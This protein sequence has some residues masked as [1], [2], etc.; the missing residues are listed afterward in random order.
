[1][2]DNK[3][4]LYDALSQDY[5]LGTFEQFESDIA[6]AG[7][8][9]KLYDATIEEYDFG[10]F[11]EFENQ[12]GFAPQAQSAPRLGADKSVYTFTAEELGMPENTYRSESTSVAKSPEIKPLG[13]SRVSMGAEEDEP[14]TTFGEGVKQGADAIY[15]G[16]KYFAGEQARFWNGAQQDAKKALEFLDAQGEDFDA[17]GWD[18][19]KAMNEAAQKQWEKDYEEFLKVKEARR[20]ERKESGMGLWERI[21]H[22]VADPSM[23]EP[24]ESRR[25]NPANM[26]YQRPLLTLNDALK[27]ADGDVAKARAILEKKAS[28]E[29]WAD[30]TMREASE[31]MA[32]HKPVE[33][34]AWWG[35]MVPQVAGQATAIGASF[36]PGVGGVLGKVLSYGTTAGLTASSAG[37]AMA[38]ARQA[39]ASDEEVWSAG[40]AQAVIEAGS[41]QIP[42]NRLIGKTGS[43]AFKKG[44]KAVADN[45][46]EKELEKLLV[47][48]NKRLGGKLLSGKTAKEL[49][50]DMG[51][52][53]ASEFVAEFLGTYVP[54]I[55]AD[56]E[57]YPTLLEAVK[58]GWEGAKAGFA[59]GGFLGGGS[60]ALSNT[61]NENRRKKQGFV[62]LANDK[63]GNVVEVIGE[64]EGLVT[65][66]TQDGATK[67]YTLEELSN[68]GT[69]SYDEWK[70]AKVDVESRYIEGY[71]QEPTGA[72]AL[73]ASEEFKTAEMN[74][75]TALGLTND[76]DVDAY[77][78][79]IPAE[80]LAKGDEDVLDIINEYKTAKARFEGIQ[81]KFQDTR[82]EQYRESDNSINAR[83][84]NGV[85]F[86]VTTD[87]GV[88]FITGGK[89]VLNDEGEIDYVNS[90]DLVAMFPDGKKKPVKNGSLQGKVKIENAEELKAVRRA[91]ID[92]KWK[93]DFDNAETAANELQKREAGL[94]FEVTDELG[95]HTVEVLEEG[96]DESKI[97]FDGEETP[98]GTE[99]LNQWREMA[100]VSQTE[101]GELKTENEQASHENG[102]V[103]GESEVA[104]V[105]ESIPTETRG[106]EERAAYHLVSIERTM[107]DLHDGTLE[108]DEI[109]GLI[110]ARIKEAE[111]DVKNVEKKKPVIGADKNAYVAAKQ[112]WQADMEAVK[113]KLDYY[114]Q[115]KAINAEATRSEM[116]EA[117]EAV[118]PR[119]V[120]EKT[121][122]EFVASVMPKIT[123]ESFK[124]ETGLK[125]SEQKALVGVIAGEGNGG[126]TIE[127]AA[128]IVLENYED[129]LRG[130]GFNGD[131]QDVRDMIINILSNGN[132]R[133]YAK[134]GAEMRAQQSVEEQISQLEGIAIGMGFKDTNEMIAYEEAVVPRIIQDYTGFDE[135]EYFNN[136]AENIKYD[137]TRESE[138]TRGSS[139][140]LQGKQPADN[141][142][143]TN[144]GE[145]G[146][147]G[148]V[149][150]DVYSGGQNATPQGNQ[151]VNGS[152]FPNNQNRDD[153]SQVE[154][155]AEG[156]NTPGQ[157]GVTSLAEHANGIAESLGLNITLYNDESTITDKEVMQAITEGGIVKGWYNPR[158]GEIALFLP[159]MESMRDVESTI[160]HEA[161]SH[162]GIKHFLNK[163]FDKFLDGVWEM[164]P[165]GTRAHFL[166][167]VGADMKNPSKAK[168]RQAADEYV[169]HI[170]EKMDLNELEKSVWQRFIDYVMDA[171]R[172]AGFK[173]LKQRDVEAVIRASY[174][175]LRK[176]GNVK[177]ENGN[178]S[179]VTGLGETMQQ[180]MFSK[181]IEAL[182]DKFNE[183]LQQQ[184]DG[185]L[186]KGHIYQLGMPSEVLMAT[187]IPQLP[188]QLNST[189]LQ[190][191]STN[192]GHDYSIEEIKDLVKALHNPLAVFVYGDKTKAQNIVVEI[193]SYDKNFV[194]GLALRPKVGGRVL[195][196][197]S[198][199]NVF[200]KDNAEWLNWISQ[201]KALYLDKERVQTLIDQQRTSLADVDYLDLNSIANVINNFEN[202]T[203]ESENSAE[204]PQDSES[205]IRLRKVT[206]EMDAE[207]MTA[208]ENGDMET[209]E[210]LVKEAAKLA[211]PDTKVVD[212]D[213]YPMP[214]F[215]GD[216][217]KGRYVFSTDTFF[218][219]N[220]Q[221]AKRY[222]GGTG[223]VYPVY[224]NIENP[225]DV[226]D[227]K[228]RDIFTEFSGGRVPVKT[229]TGALDWG[230][231]TYEDLQEYIEENYPGEYDGFILD[232]GGEPDY[233]GNVV[234]RGLSYI[235]FTSSQAKYSSAVTYD[236]N[237]NVIPL[238][239]RFNEEKEDIRFRKVFHG[240]GAKFDKFDHSFM[241]TGEGAQAYGWGTYVTEVEDI[242][243]T[244]ATT[245][246]DKLISEK[247]KENA[248]INKLAKQTLESSNGNK[249]EALDY[250]RG[251]LN[252]SWSDKKRVK[253]QIKIIETGKFL[254]ETKVK[255]HLYNVEIPDDNGSNYLQ[256]EEI[257]PKE[258]ESAV[259]ERLLEKLSEGQGEAYKSDLKQK[260]DDVFRLSDYSGHSL[261]NNVSAYVG[262][263]K[264]ASLF[265]SDMGFVGISYPA[266]ATTG[267]RADGARNYVIFNEDDAVIEDR[268]MFRR[269]NK[270]QDIFVS[271]AQRA[272]EGIK[273]EK[274]TPEQWI[275]MLKK[276]GGLKAGEEAW[277]GLKEWL[278]EKGKVKGENG[279]V[280]P[281]TK[282][283]IL[284]FI[285]ENKIQIEEVNYTQFGY[286]LMDEAT[287][288]LE[289]EL[290][291]IGWDAMAE[292]Y[293]GFD[294]L[295]EVYD[296][297]LLWSEERASV[298]EYEDFIIDNKIVDLDSQS[299][300]IN[301]TREKYTTEGLE[302]KREIA[303][304]VP[305]IEPYNAS[306]E[307]HF[308]DAGNGRAVAWVRFGET[309]DSEGNRVLVIDEIQSKRHQDGREKGY[310]DASNLTAEKQENGIWHIFDNG[311]FVA[312]VAKWNA[313]TEQEAVEY[314]AK[315]LIP[316][317]PFEKNWHELAMKRMLRLAAEEGFD[318][319]AWTT[320]EQQAERYNLGA[321]LKGLKAY[322]TSA[323][324]YYVIPYNNGA[325]G[326]FVK[327]YTEQELADTFGKELA[328]KIITNAEN[329][330][331]EN[332][333][334]IEGE[335]LRVGGE[336]MKGFYDRML[337]SFVQKYTKKWGAKVGEVTMP[338]LRENNT[339]HSVDVTPEM[340]ESVME[341][342][343]MFSK[344]ISYDDAVQIAEDF[345][346]TFKG[347]AKKIVV[348]KGNDVL[349]QQMRDAGFDEEDIALAMAATEQELPPMAGHLW[350]SDGIVVFRYDTD[351]NLYEALWHE[352]THRALR[353]IYGNNRILAQARFDELPEHIKQEYVDFL[354]AA[355]Y[356]E[357]EYAEETLCYFVGSR[358]RLIGYLKD[359]RNDLTSFYRF[360]DKNYKRFVDFAQNLI[361]YTVYHEE[362]TEHRER[363]AGFG[364][365]AETTTEGGNGVHQR[366][367]EDGGN[368]QGTATAGGLTEEVN[369][370]EGET[371]FRK[372]V[373][374]EEVIEQ[375]E[376]NEESIAKDAVTQL[377]EALNAP[378]TIIDD[379][380]SLPEN[381]RN[382]K[383]W[384]DPKTGE[385]VV[386]VPNHVSSED[387]VQTVLHEVVGHRG[388]RAVLGEKFDEFLDDVFKKA[389]PEVKRGISDKFFG[390]LRKGHALTVREATEE[391]I[392]ELAERGFEGYNGVWNS[393]KQW[394]K[395]A[396]RSLVGFE[397]TDNELRYLLWKSYNR[398]KSGPIEAILDIA[399]E[400]KTG[401]GNTMFRVVE[402]YN[403]GVQGVWNKAKEGWYDE[404]RS[405]K[406]AQEAIEKELGR[407]V[408][409]SEN[410]Y[411]Y[412][413]HLPS[414][415]KNKKEV[416]DNKYLKPFT[417][418]LKKLY[419][420]EVNGQKMDEKSVERY[421]NAKHG[422]ER[423]REMS[424]KKAL[425]E[426]QDGKKVFNEEAYA[427][428]AQERDAVRKRKLPWTE[429]QRELDKVAKKYGAKIRDYSGLTAIFDAEGKMKYAQIADSAYKYV[430]DVES[431][432]GKDIKELWKLIKG[433]TD[434]SLKEAYESGMMS[435]S[436]YEHIKQ[437]YKYYVPLRGFTKQTAE[438]FFDYVEGDHS[439]LN[440]VVKT[441]KGRTSEAENIFATILNMANSAIVQGSKNR[442]KQRLLN[443]AMRSRTGLLS[444]DNAWYA[445]VGDEYIP[446]EYPENA[447]EYAAFEERMKELEKNGEVVRHRPGLEIGRKVADKWNQQ[448]HAVRVKRNGREYIVWV[449]GDPRL[450]NAVNGM[451][452]E[453]FDETWIGALNRWRAQMVTQYSPTFIF[454]NLV[455]DV[456]EA[457]MTYA[458][459]RGT[460]M[461]GN[462]DLNVAANS[463]KMMSLYLKYKKG[464][465][466]EEIPVERYFKEFLENGGETGYTEMIS[467]EQYEKQLKKLTE[468]LN[469]KNATERAFEAVGEGVEFANRCI[470]NLCRFSAYQT[471]REAGMSILKS[472]ED[473]KEVSV[474]FNRKG[475][476]AMGQKW[477][478]AFFM[479]LNPAIQSLAK[480]ILLTKKF[481]KKM[482]AVW[483]GE[484]VMGATAPLLWS[485]I[486]SMFGDDEDKDELMGNYFNLTDYRR[487]S[488]LCMPGKDGVFHIPLSHEARALYGL[489]ELFTSY[490]MG[491]EEY[492]NL[493]IQIF[494]T[495][496]QS[497]PLNPLD[498]WA[499]GENILES[500]AYSLTPDAVKPIAEVIMNRDF[501]GN[502]VHNRSDFNEFLPEY[503]R[504][505]RGTADIY[506]S[507]SKVLSGKEIYGKGVLD[508]LVGTLVNPSTMEHLVEGYLGG[509]YSF[510]DKAV[511]TGKWI[512]GNEEFAEFKNVPIGSSFYTS[513]TKYEDKP[514]EER[515]RRDWEDAFKFYQQEVKYYDDKETAAKNGEKNGEE[516]GTLVLEQMERNGEAL[517]VDIFNDGNDRL[518]ELYSAS[519]VA[520]RNREF[521]KVQEIDKQIYAEKMDIVE[522]MEKL[523]DD[524]MIGYTF[525]RNK[526]KGVYGELETYGDVR[527]ANII[528]NFQTELKPI[529]DEYMKVEDWKAYKKLHEKE[530]GM[531]EDLKRIE[532]DIS[533]EKSEM[534][535]NP[536]YAEEGMTEIRTLRAEAVE[537]IN[538]YRNE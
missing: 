397:V 459:R 470:E 251:L 202:P 537:L 374:E 183:E 423:N 80:D 347:A 43:A 98:I 253:A 215:H 128:E 416:F 276:N 458:V 263:D 372:N 234:H 204:I 393:I 306:D 156:E 235:P 532:S 342:Q 504:G 225:F 375:Q 236:D 36:I 208:V 480:R 525:R 320:G 493:P 447:D 492:D 400:A 316:S 133:S 413:N 521:D 76:E 181:D 346:K 150:G 296:G 420:L 214:M 328:Q 110:D 140:L 45:I 249:E 195:E 516:S 84:N 438:D 391:Y 68:I 256:W 478:K 520:R 305:T 167:Y 130:L 483:A 302:R 57:S 464:A 378:V 354:K 213:G 473:A 538:K 170:A 418:L 463:V 95:T 531:Y 352:N 282:Q 69:F 353:K 218:T 381:R 2:N 475:S 67:D 399:M 312:P 411:L 100:G 172:K 182:N 92:A 13:V 220:E 534:K 198:I 149:Q 450:A 8:R 46:P 72:V 496:S 32:K 403:E 70:N 14:L 529:Q 284:D 39:G 83:A 158:T 184:I 179:Q 255:A 360:V 178:V 441:A 242:G 7:K 194:V 31:A 186:P 344:K 258:V 501:A 107:E 94:L 488:G 428:W 190:E 333:Y 209:A 530:L 74:V 440:A 227:E 335:E 384:F 437:M 349:E 142:G 299:N 138:G 177:T 402:D 262:G 323:N 25:I 48:G 135:T 102:N 285:G 41:E 394:L 421:T 247:H 430:E 15:Q 151:Q 231:Y 71:E 442:L 290:K 495:L 141:A 310:K 382:K 287:R 318:K 289:A 187:G 206:P 268:T 33:G 162:Y 388:L 217:K 404:M 191:K 148:E 132:P 477:A 12:L 3:R 6:D 291:E 155:A 364:E 325:I 465:L 295:F 432:G 176:N 230:E 535:E 58:N 16:N 367:S 196:I 274:A 203:I 139:E 453:N 82:E 396:F 338:N 444:V 498:G 56:K 38:E 345:A 307:V 89:V 137:T 356:K 159:A 383:G 125:N 398:Q 165:A 425:T 173:N 315:N 160:L 419:E 63:D 261:Y 309:T 65:V 427:A 515:T 81:D 508:N 37:Q 248:I 313:N 75:R 86:S 260:L 237:G 171:L 250:L 506:K 47:E 527:D 224:L 363:F 326:E 145:P 118:K 452:R 267:D 62:E 22:K 472:I 51:V 19:R 461:M 451:L 50:K 66:L 336:G 88:V 259:K 280:E 131:V 456:Q 491:H 126:V 124:K 265:L 512:L 271:N 303:L 154:G 408:L 24:L 11:S 166:Q 222:T 119:D 469:M 365:I 373:T 362:E 55:Y 329:A 288:K 368:A 192:Y 533:Y 257:V 27:E 390:A 28:E 434:Y 61:L 351:E 169:A 294:E 73:S 406:V 49:I 484:F 143:A 207:Y 200:P 216:R 513:L 358:P 273:Q 524:P 164:M 361:D 494:N 377:G 511:K 23:P 409:D 244:Y 221:Y 40:V 53:G 522:R 376:E 389:S 502:K 197:N 26:S 277:L 193:Q 97:L 286:G 369:S 136:L 343:T 144:L 254:P 188:I 175:N 339:M 426:V 77:I 297:E 134:K 146:Q 385:V 238:S 161:V 18:V 321:V 111:N 298:G 59:M 392:A 474:N 505:K 90:K 417:S 528:N 405:I 454:T 481:P 245:M 35:Q 357:N 278:T 270:N 241:G 122:D 232:E 371:L 180:T 281:V 103:E 272:V 189:K 311:E 433:M 52:E 435:K 44:Y 283:E 517:M 431:A 429:E 168:M 503:M 359:G 4:K 93:A 17:K 229:T 233:N 370:Q 314:Y 123:P 185:T 341:G 219:P 412:A 439:P 327:E 42:L 448:Q 212:E 401:T 422:I 117:V 407:E 129:E 424:V 275:A 510:A 54:I 322:K 201:G 466:N 64:K 115:L 264:Q 120:V 387:A 105:V 99:E 482:A 199:R 104:P 330:T 366:N 518:K 500:M 21:L 449:N 410:V 514:R 340:Q 317:A 246:R 380:N 300:A 301:E 523:A 211:M 446:V 486:R 462:F 279:K 152:E 87:N 445:K 96:A 78:A 467:I 490:V 127:Q 108:P 205:G 519:D 485:L 334:E 348:S 415:N 240:S 153:V 243:R 304:T 116:R 174:A 252:E 91:E 414:I 60:T 226:R 507:V 106:K 308:G 499:P 460:K 337:P 436:T 395:D 457:S 85:V 269:A 526:I 34:A 509:A 109:E 223:E 350:G 468:G 489:G 228:A 157:N 536:A 5:D 386:V 355:G 79:N 20:K 379:L 147:G 101:N 479:F 1:M 121:A 487:R 163:D 497:L 10:D 30:K 114:N 455:R 210:R 9:R 266:N 112:Q 324:E 331:E 443:L 471:S 319:V 113:A 293:P 239:E 292:K 332:P 29:Q 476:G